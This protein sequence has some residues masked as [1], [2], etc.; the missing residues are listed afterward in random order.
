MSS[1]EIFCYS[2]PAIRGYQA[3]SPFYVTIFPLKYIN[4]LFAKA[5]SEISPELKAQRTLNTNRIP[6]MAAYI[7]NNRDN[8]VFSSLTASISEEVIFE[9]INNQNND[10]GT[11]KVPFD[12][13]VLINDGQHRRAAIERAIEEDESLMEESI[14]IVFYID[15]DLNRSQQM[16][17]D[18]NRHAVKPAKS[19]GILY[20]HRDPLAQ[21]CASLIQKVDVFVGMTEK[22]KATLSNR[23]NKMFTLSSIYKATGCLLG[24]KS[25]DQIKNNDQKLAVTFWNEIAKNIPDWKA[26]KNRE[27]APYVLRR[28]F[29]HTHGITLQALAN[30]GN[31]L[32]HS[33]NNWKEVLNKIKK[34]DWSRDNAKNWHGRVIVHGKINKGSKHVI[35]LTNFIKNKIKLPL[36]DHEKEVEAAFIESN[37]K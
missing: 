35:L 23:E 37:K 15:K 16:F 20:D 25:G 6:E 19:L 31:E 12:A 11:L 5:E 17:A 32:I 9:C 22:E 18:L 29:I 24:Y 1:K 34:I 14:S 26:A 21:L 8:Y 13:K 36:S 28:D 27:I 33:K 10:I 7:I 4:S 30:V 2:I 3:S